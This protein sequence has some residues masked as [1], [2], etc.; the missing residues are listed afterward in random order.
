MKLPLSQFSKL[1]LFLFLSVCVS[2]SF[3]QSTGEEIIGTWWNQEKDGQIEIYKSG[4]TYA[5]KLVWMK[6]QNDPATGKLLLDK[7]NPDEKLRSKPLLGSNLMY[8]FT[9]SKQENE[10]NNGKIYDGRKGKTYKC[11]LRIQADHVLKVTGYLGAS[12]MGL[13][14]TTIWTRIK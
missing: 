2:Q 3:G 1:L 8:G 4:N 11:L 6:D 7:K 10:W 14:E 9:F 13:C 12:W 5:G